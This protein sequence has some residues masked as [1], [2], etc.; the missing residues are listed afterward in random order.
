MEEIM[1]DISNPIEA[2]EAKSTTMKAMVFAAIWIGVLS[3]TKGILSIFGKEFLGMDNII[4]SGIT[5]AG[6]FSPVFISIW[7]DKLKAI[8]EITKIGEK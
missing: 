5:I 2:K 1:A 3:I 6:V 8:K 4:I 7:L